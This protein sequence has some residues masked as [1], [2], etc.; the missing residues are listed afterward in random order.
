MIDY[1]IVEY[2]T[3]IVLPATGLDFQPQLGTSFIIKNIKISVN[4]Q[5]GVRPVQF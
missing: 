2:L 1:F 5:T 4:L 3:W